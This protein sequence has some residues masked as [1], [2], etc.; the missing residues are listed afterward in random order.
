MEGSG[1]KVKFDFT[2]GTGDW[3]QTHLTLDTER[4]CTKLGKYWATQ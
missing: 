4:E 2:T 1:F 3:V